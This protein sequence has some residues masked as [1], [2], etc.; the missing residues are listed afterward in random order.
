MVV[1]K[2]KQGFIVFLVVLILGC[3]SVPTQPVVPYGM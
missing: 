1:N 3:S 2:I